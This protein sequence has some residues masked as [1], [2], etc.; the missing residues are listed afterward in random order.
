MHPLART[1]S[2]ERQTRSGRVGG[3][4]VLEGLD[5]RTAEVGQ[6]VGVCGS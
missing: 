5:D 2:A 4:P 1:G 6:V 3:G